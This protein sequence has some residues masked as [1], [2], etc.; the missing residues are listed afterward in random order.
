MAQQGKQQEQQDEERYYKA[1][2]RFEGHNDIE[3][4]VNPGD[5]LVSSSEYECT[6]VCVGYSG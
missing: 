6:V 2:Y 4:T 3:L 1:V 5:V